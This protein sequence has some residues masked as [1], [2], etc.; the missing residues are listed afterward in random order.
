[1]AP[2]DGSTLRTKSTLGIVLG[3]RRIWGY[4]DQRWFRIRDHVDVVGL[5]R[6]MQ[7]ESRA[8][9]LLTVRAMTGVAKERRGKQAVTHRCA[10]TTARDCWKRLGCHD[11][12]VRY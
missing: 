10:G 7:G 8:G 6:E 2:K 11:A 9:S 4:R 12:S 1:M 3:L 5:D